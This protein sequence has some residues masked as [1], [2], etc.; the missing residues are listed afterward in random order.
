M[1]WLT[2]LG[3]LGFIGLLILFLIYI[4][5]PNYQ[6][7]SVSTT[8]VWKLSLKYRKK[9][10][11]I[12]KLRNILLIICQV[13]IVCTCAFML[14][15]PFV[16]G[17]DKHSAN[18]KIIVIDASG[19]MLAEVAG[20]TR[21][22]RAVTQAKA[23]INETLDQSSVVSVI[24]A[25]KEANFVFQR[26]T[27]DMRTTLLREL[28]ALVD[29]N[30]FKCTYGAS[31][32]DGSMALAESVLELNAK[33]EV[34]LFTGTTYIDDG[35][36]TVRYVSDPGEKNVSIANVSATREDNIYRIEADMTSYGSNYSGTLN[37]T[38]TG[39]QGT[40][41][42][43]DSIQ[44][45]NN[46]TLNFSCNVD[47]IKGERTKFRFGAKETYD[48]S[49]LKIYAYDS[50]YCYIAEEDSLAI[51]NAYYLY[52]GTPQK[53][54]IQYYSTLNNIFVN[55]ML[56]DL[57][58][59]L[60]DDWDIDIKTIKDSEDAILNGNG[61]EGEIEFEGY[62]IY[63]FEHRIPEKLPTDGL[64][65]LLY[66]DE[67]PESMEITLSP[68]KTVTGDGATFTAGASHPILE[69]VN[70]SNIRSTRY[71]TIPNYDSCY[72]PLLY[73]NGEP[74]ALAKNEPDSKVLILTFNFHY[75]NFPII[76]EYPTFM[77]N[78]LNYF[79]PTTFDKNVYNL[80]DTV[81]LNSRSELLTVAG[82]AFAE[83][84]EFKTTPAEIYVDVPGSYTVTQTP[85][86]GNKIVEN[87]SVV[88]PEEQSDITRQ[89]D[90]LT[91]PF[92]PTLEE[93]IDLD[94]VIYFA[95]ALVT[96]LFCEWWLKSR[97]N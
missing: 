78:T 79:I 45:L 47:L 41:G 71:K 5:K 15:Q 17:E 87:F 38:I 18:E 53:L 3:F 89:V 73:A 21:F 80:Y 35:N 28:D 91:N 23:L 74:V 59:Q 33:A 95:I 39:A 1:N 4:L 31:D 61:K 65:I 66:P 37:V 25:D 29:P 34:V 67:V 43:G 14:A 12:S 90:A 24:L 60:R 81:V 63:I 55:S 82:P 22:E 51:D 88:I 62:D 64:V 7:K 57:Q 85:I 93:N 6:N 50:I 49:D 69:Y 75:S 20:E 36:V 92:F 96:L 83:T 19:S 56:L 40:F 46:E 70:A 76:P 68:V 8:Y 10:I 30:D 58:D 9:K 97:D 16:A 42:V 2:P 77:I 84:L 86:S 13:L 26:A 54:K 94:L 48:V 72:T 27:A 52:G 11:P 32:I 44:S